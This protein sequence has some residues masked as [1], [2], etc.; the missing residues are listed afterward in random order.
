MNTARD[1]HDNIM[2]C[3]EGFCGDQTWCDYFQ[4]SVTVV[5]TDVFRWDEIR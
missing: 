5:F 1:N 4:L 3:V 2:A